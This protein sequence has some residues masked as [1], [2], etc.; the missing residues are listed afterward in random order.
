V[1]KIKVICEDCKKD[2]N[3]LVKDASRFGTDALC[4]ECCKE[5]NSYPENAMIFYQLKP[6][7]SVGSQLINYKK[8]KNFIIIL[9][10]GE[11]DDM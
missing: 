1:K 3:F 2:T 5:Q 10:E 6:T 4:E 8:A 7:M 9:D 11:H